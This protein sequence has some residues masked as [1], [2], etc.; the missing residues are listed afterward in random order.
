MSITYLFKQAF[1][2]L[3]KKWG[4]NLI[5]VGSIA[6]SF[7]VFNIFLLITHNLQGVAQKL[8]EKVQ[9]EVYLN[10]NITTEQINSLGK[11]IQGFPEVEKVEY[12]SKE[13]AFIQMENYMG[14]DLLEGLDSNSLPASF[15]VSLKKEQRGFQKSDLVAS[16][17]L[18]KEGVEDVEFGGDWL[19]KLDQAIFIFFIVDL[20]FGI[21]ITLA[22]TLIVSNFM[23]ILGLSRTEAVQIMSLLGAKKKDIA[24]PFLIQG[25]ILGGTGAVLGL[26][27]VWASCSIF[28]TRI[29][30]IAFL[31]LYM[32]GGLIVWGM[33]LGAGGSLLSIR[34]HQ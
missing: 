2:D 4:V 28:S 19:K 17:V 6:S 18:N 23:R 29:I 30:T 5:L 9:V 20:V 16:K 10:E 33:L 14:K 24:F 22:V 21:F 25:M 3:S 27:L 8:R 1:H 31:P 32:R 26:L 12:R 11:I 13:E 34:K 15:L 7:L